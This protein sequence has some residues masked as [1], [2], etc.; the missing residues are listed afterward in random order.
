MYIAYI[1]P[2]HRV[3]R[4]QTPFLVVQNRRLFAFQ[5]E[6]YVKLLDTEKYVNYK[7]IQSNHIITTNRIRTKNTKC[8]KGGKMNKKKQKSTNS[9]LVK[10][11]SHMFCS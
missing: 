6:K 7:K 10:I 3:Q 2:L 5:R 9:N 4:S 8:E 1:V 11:L